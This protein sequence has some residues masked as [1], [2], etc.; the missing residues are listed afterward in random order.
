V[1]ASAANASKS[2]DR[3]TVA[4][5][6]RGQTVKGTILGDVSF[7]ANGQAQHKPTIFKVVDGKTAK[8]EVV[9]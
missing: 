2:L 4:G 7:E 9:K 1:W 5:A 3:K 8:I 6:I